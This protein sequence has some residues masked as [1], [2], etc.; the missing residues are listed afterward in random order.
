MINN[1]LT[2][3]REKIQFKIKYLINIKHYLLFIHSPI[4]NIIHE[5]T[6]A[7]NFFFKQI[8]WSTCQRKNTQNNIHTNQVKNE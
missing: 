6:R 7:L 2:N 1:G 4:I 8:E 3:V 5:G